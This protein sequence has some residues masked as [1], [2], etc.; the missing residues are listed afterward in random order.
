MR[1]ALLSRSN[2]KAALQLVIRL[3]AH[4]H[5]HWL[6]IER[7]PWNRRE[8]VRKR[9][10]KGPNVT[11]VL[12]RRPRLPIHGT[13]IGGVSGEGQQLTFSPGEP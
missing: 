11:L 9:P 12:R 1:R 4:S 2:K 13:Y 5:R 7:R 3:S 6:A 8:M 10:Q